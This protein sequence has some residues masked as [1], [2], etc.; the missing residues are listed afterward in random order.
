MRGF[1]YVAPATM[2]FVVSVRPDA[3]NRMLRV[4]VD[5]EAMYRSSEVALE[6]DRAK[7]LH[8]FEFRGMPQ[9]AYVVRAVVLSSDE[10]RAL[11][12]QKVV[13]S[14]VTPGQ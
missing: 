7:R 4:E 8:S 11:T 13:V 2:P 10:V 12:E 9:G 6:G 5:G 1:V 14:S 3:D